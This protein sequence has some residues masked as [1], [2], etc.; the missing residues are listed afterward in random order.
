M[1]ITIAFLR[2]IKNLYVTP[3][4]NIFASEPKPI[5]ALNDNLLQHGLAI[6]IV[7]TVTIRFVL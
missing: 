2:I 4:G 1:K 6:D 7:T 5:K 3:A